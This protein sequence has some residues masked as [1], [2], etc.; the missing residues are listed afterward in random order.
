[1]TDTITENTAGDKGA[2]YVSHHAGRYGYDISVKGLT[3]ISGNK[4]GTPMRANIVLEFYG[5]THNYI[6]CAGLY[7]GSE[8]V[9]SALKSG[10]VEVLR[11][12]DKYQLRYFHSENGSLSFEGKATVEAPLVTASLFSSG[13]IIA[14]IALA[15]VAAGAGAAAITYKMKKKKGG[16]DGNDEKE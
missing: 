12:V 14:I 5:A 16:A 2:V 15:L 3:V 1:V 6:Y 4:S 13:S 8:V 11:N 7:E 10:K 9:F